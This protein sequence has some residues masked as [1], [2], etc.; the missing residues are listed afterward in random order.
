MVNKSLNK[1]ADRIV[2]AFIKNKTSIHIQCRKWR[3][4]ASVIQEVG[5]WFSYR[6]KFWNMLQAALDHEESFVDAPKAWKPN[7]QRV[8]EVWNFKI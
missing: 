6:N 4:S 1:Y 8:F 7:V 5:Q 3:R 2:K